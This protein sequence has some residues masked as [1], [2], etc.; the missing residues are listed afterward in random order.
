MFCGKKESNT[1]WKN[2][3]KN[4]VSNLRDDKSHDLGKCRMQGVWLRKDRLGQ[5][6][7]KYIWFDQV[8][9]QCVFKLIQAE[10]TYVV[11]LG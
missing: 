3:Q 6:G 10:L 7:L 4:S 2:T 9:L 11:E 5:I 1:F 8:E